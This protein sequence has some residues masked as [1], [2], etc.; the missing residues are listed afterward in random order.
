MSLRFHSSRRARPYHLQPLNPR[1]HQVQHDQ[2]GALGLVGVQG[3]LSVAGGGDVEP[4]S[5]QVLLEDLLNNGLVVKDELASIGRRHTRIVSAGC[6]ET[7]K[8]SAGL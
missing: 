1:K 7:L 5:I 6:C 4:S 2:V 3:A 8:R